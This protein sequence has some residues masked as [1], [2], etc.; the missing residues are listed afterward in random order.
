MSI[1]SV[2]EKGHAIPGNYTLG[3]RIS[4]V[5]GRYFANMHKNV[6][7]AKSALI[8][9]DARIH[10][11]VGQIVIGEQ[12]I[13]AP[14]AVLQ[15]NIELGENTSVQYNTLIVGY[16]ELGDE[17]GLIRIGN[18][19][20]I[21]ANCMII[22]ANHVFQDPDIPICKQGVEPSHITI[23]DDVWIGGGVHIIAGVTIGTGAV[24]GAGSVVT[25]DI[26]PYSV[27]V[28]VPAKVKSFRK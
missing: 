1:W 18:N 28:G 15:G 8:S 23:E 6:H 16:G 2:L 13:I 12:C 25:H 21:A 9:P 3:S 14:H 4:S 7:I 5:C 10:P 19:V 27:A 22:S 26:P 20:R 24:I 17:K 11:R